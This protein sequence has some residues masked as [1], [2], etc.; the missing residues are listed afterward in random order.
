[1]INETLMLSGVGVF[2][3]FGHLHGLGVT[4]YNA[5]KGLGKKRRG[6]YRGG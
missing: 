6:D 2:F 5:N 3:Y 4:W 1:M